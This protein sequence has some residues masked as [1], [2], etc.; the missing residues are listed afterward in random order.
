M[1]EFQFFAR[2]VFNPQMFPDS[3]QI[4]VTVHDEIITVRLTGFYTDCIY[5]LSSITGKT[6]INER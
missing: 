3:I 5:G 1:S 4:E 6:L 2:Y